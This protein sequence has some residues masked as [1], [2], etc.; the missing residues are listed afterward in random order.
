MGKYDLNWKY[1]DILRVPEEKLKDVTLIEYIPGTHGEYFSLMLNSVY[2]N[3]VCAPEYAFA[4]RAHAPKQQELRKFY[5]FH[6]AYDSEL[7]GLLADND[8]I[9]ITIDTFEG[10]LLAVMLALYRT[11]LPDSVDLEHLTEEQFEELNPATG[12]L[13]YGWGD[14]IFNNLKRPF[15]RASLRH[16]LATHVMPGMNDYYRTIYDG[17]MRR[18]ICQ[19]SFESFFE[20]DTFFNS[21]AHVNKILNLNIDLTPQ[22]PAMQHSF[23]EFQRNNPFCRIFRE[24]NTVVDQ[25]S[26][27]REVQIPKLHVATEALIIYKVKKEFGLDLLLN[28]DFYT[29]TTDI[30][31]QIRAQDKT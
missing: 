21:V 12:K 27:K 22:I 2:E 25:I 10:M 16:T 30:I 6:A 23:D 3:K 19:V 20:F 29:S 18:S 1:F 13:N 15:S 11:R 28:D 7:S 24:V 8:R 5:P 14:L 9:T 31:S 4:G 17:L 26:Q